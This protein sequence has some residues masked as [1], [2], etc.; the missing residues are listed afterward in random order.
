[1][2]K[3]ISILFFACIML[4]GCNQKH[5]QETSNISFEAADTKEEKDTTPPVISGLDEGAIV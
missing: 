3:K 4:V 1:M 2:F 5:S